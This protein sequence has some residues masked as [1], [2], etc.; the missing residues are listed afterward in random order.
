M[1]SSSFDSL[2][3][4]FLIDRRNSPQS[5]DITERVALL[6]LQRISTASS[7]DQILTIISA[8]ATNIGEHEELDRDKIVR[9]AVENTY[10]LSVQSNLAA[11]RPHNLWSLLSF[12]L[13]HIGRLSLKLNSKFEDGN[14]V[15]IIEHS[16]GNIWSLFIRDLLVMIFQKLGKIKPKISINLNNTIVVS[17]PSSSKPE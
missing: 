8:L 2:I 7:I 4:N 6:A 15:L 17:F 5:D 12:V 14:Y 1:L 16:M 11:N 13:E 3:A 10:C 9:S